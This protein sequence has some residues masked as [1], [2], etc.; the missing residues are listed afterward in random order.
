MTKIAVHMTGGI[1]VYK[2]VEV[3]RGLQKQGHEVRVAM[4]QN[5]A[6]F[7]GPA[8]LAALTK[9]PVL[10]DQW[11]A[12]LNGQVPHIELADWSELALVV[13]ACV[14]YRHTLLQA[15]LLPDPLP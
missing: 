2:A 14:P 12:T 11:A 13:P 4:T 15:C 10:I 6:R 7:V 3:V 8:T 9:H 1:A 5:A